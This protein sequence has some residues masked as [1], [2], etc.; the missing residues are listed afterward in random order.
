MATVRTL[1]VRAPGTNRDE[2]TAYAFRQAG[3]ETET[4]HVTEL[5]AG[6]KRFTDYQILVFPGGFSYGDDL[7]AGRVQANELTMKLAREVTPY[8]ERGGLIMGICNGFQMLVKAGILPG[9]L[10]A[11]VGQTATLTNNDAGRFECR[12]V[13]LAANQ[14]SRCIFT[15]GIDVIYAPIAH[16]EG[17]F[18]APPEVLD[19]VDVALYYADAAG[20]PVTAYPACPNGSLRAIAG[21]TDATGH[22][23]GL[24]PHPEDNIH[25]LH[26]PRWTKGG[27]E[28]VGSGIKI[29]RNA[30]DWVKSS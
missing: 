22:I 7:G 1:I 29:F 26:H 24:M 18:V 21:I 3:A 19:N 23:F 9:P 17:K 25:P 16:G 8:I 11:G 27:A 10:S 14:N 13:Y 20:N 28:L 30:V 12:W 5:V 4:A 2:E 15:R 6:A